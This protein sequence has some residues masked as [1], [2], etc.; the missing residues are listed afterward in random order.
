ML[1]CLISSAAE[2]PLVPATFP[3][4]PWHRRLCT[5]GTRNIPFELLHISWYKG[6]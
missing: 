4:I 5:S 6:R 2:V 3:T 1:H